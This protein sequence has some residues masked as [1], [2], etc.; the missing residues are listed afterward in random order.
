M[1]VIIG[2]GD[3]DNDGMI[4]FY[5][6]KFDGSVVFYCKNGDLMCWSCMDVLMNFGDLCVV[7]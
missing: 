1:M 6:C 7:G 4:D 3:I 2:V 5:V